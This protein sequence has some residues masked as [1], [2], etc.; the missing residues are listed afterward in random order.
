MK[1][2]FTNWIKWVGHRP[3]ALI[4]LIGLLVIIIGGASVFLYLLNKPIDVLENWTVQTTKK[5]VN[6]KLPTYNPGG[7][8]EFISTSHKIVSAEGV[9]TRIFNCDPTSTNDAREIALS[10][11]PAEPADDRSALGRLPVV[12]GLLDSLGL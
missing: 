7:T 12:G 1:E 5:E 10:P 11:A 6:G 8:L 3:V 9:T 2:R 4:N